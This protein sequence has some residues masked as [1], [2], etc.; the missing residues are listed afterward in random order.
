MESNL[1][2]IKYL[3][4]MIKVYLRP[5]QYNDMAIDTLEV[6]LGKNGIEYRKYVDTIYASF[7][8]EEHTGLIEQGVMIT[9]FEG[10]KVAVIKQYIFQLECDDPEALLGALNVEKDLPMICYSEIKIKNYYDIQPV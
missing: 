10:K 3:E 2:T 7:T 5:H 4:L 8:S 6:L 1:Q 9:D